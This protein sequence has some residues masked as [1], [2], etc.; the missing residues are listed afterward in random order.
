[1]SE[2]AARSTSARPV[3]IAAA[4][5]AALFAACTFLAPLAASLDLPGAGPLYALYSPLCHQNPARSLTV[6]SAPQAV[7]ARCCGLYLGVSA[8]LIVATLFAGRLRPRRW[9]LVAAALPVLADV[10]LNLAGAPALANVPRLIV[11]LPAGW[12]AGL[13]LVEGVV[14]VAAHG[15]G[16]AKRIET[17]PLVLEEADG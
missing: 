12:V 16:P 15:L 11:A 17:A 8:A 13:F 4:L 14:D 9:W 2:R 7:C 6:A 1:M 10:A 3:L 5:L